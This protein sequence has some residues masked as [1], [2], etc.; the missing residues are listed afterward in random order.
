MILTWLKQPEVMFAL[1]LLAM[2][3]LGMQLGSL[4]TR[5]FIKDIAK[6]LAANVA[7]GRAPTTKEEIDLDLGD[8]PEPYAEHWNGTDEPP[9]TVRTL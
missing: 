1:S 4:F 6:S 7:G 3:L 2:L 8:D 5:I 9:Q